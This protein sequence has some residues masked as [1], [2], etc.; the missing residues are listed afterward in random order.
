MPSEKPP[1]DWFNWLFNR[2]YKVLEEIRSKVELIGNKGKPGGY[3]GLDSTGKIPPELLPDGQEIVLPDASLTEKGI[4]QLS[5]AT[6]GIRENVAATEKAVGQAFQAG[7][8]RK[9]EVVA[10]LVAIGV[11]ASTSE[12][13]AQLIPKIAAVIRATGDATVSDVIAGKAFSNAT[14]NGLTGNIPDRGAGGIVTPGA[15]DQTKAA[16]RYTTA[17]TIKGVPV[18]ADKVLTGTTIAGTAGTMANRGAGGLIIPGTT[19]ITKQAGY[20]SSDIIIRGEPNKIPANIK[21]GI[22][23]DGVTGTL[24]P[25]VSGQVQLA[26]DTGKA[27]IWNQTKLHDLVTVPAGTTLINWGRNGASPYG[28][29]EM[30]SNG[31]PTNRYIELVNNGNIIPIYSITEVSGLYNY[32]YLYVDL[33]AM[34]FFLIYS[35]AAQMYNTLTGVIDHNLPTTLRIRIVEDR[36]SNITYR[37]TASG[38]LH[39]A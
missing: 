36:G 28:S 29:I 3:A 35:G 6:N 23:I 34:S 24:K 33:R 19:N 2:A 4:V 1:A 30:T 5:N 21:Q 17:I 26:L 20:Y 16:G 31:N 11:Q 12:T 39:Y 13:W 8:E 25:N 38:I 27:P 18:P 9:A 7:N 10:A 22:S 37:V 32:D 15:T 14:A